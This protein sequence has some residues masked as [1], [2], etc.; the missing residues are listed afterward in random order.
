MLTNWRNVCYNYYTYAMLKFIDVH[1]LVVRVYF[2]IFQ[3][4]IIS[5]K[6]F[7]TTDSYETPKTIYHIAFSCFAPLESVFSTNTTY[8]NHTLEIIQHS[9]SEIVTTLLPTRDFVAFDKASIECDLI[10]AIAKNKKLSKKVM[11]SSVQANTIPITPLFMRLMHSFLMTSF[12]CDEFLTYLKQKR[13][14]P[15][16]SF[17]EDALVVSD[18]YLEETVFKANDK[19]QMNDG[20]LVK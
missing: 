2:Q 20:H 17:V 14:I 16:V 11:I 12:T 8:P 5:I 19:L 13:V 4:T 1:E 3:N 7:P 6:S 18:F 15:S 9:D 10:A